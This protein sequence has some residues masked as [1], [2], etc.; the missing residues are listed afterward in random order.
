[1]SWTDSLI[2]FLSQYQNFIVLIVDNDFFIIFILFINVV[3]PTKTGNWN[4]SSYLI[5]FETFK[6]SPHFMKSF[7]L[8]HDANDSPSYILGIVSPFGLNIVRTLYTP[9]I[10]YMLFNILS[11]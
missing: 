9:F 6:S 4:S 10:S 8:D 5:V 2:T 3:Y 7:A 11:N 1:M